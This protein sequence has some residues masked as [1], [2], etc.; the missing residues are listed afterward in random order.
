MVQAKGEELVLDRPAI[1]TEVCERQDKDERWRRRDWAGFIQ[2]AQQ[3]LN[4]DSLEDNL[5]LAGFVCRSGSWG[6]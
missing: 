6:I 3:C 2:M 1:S 5:Y 4:V